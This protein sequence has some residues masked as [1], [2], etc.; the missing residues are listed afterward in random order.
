MP[1]STGQ[2]T[3]TIAVLAALVATAGILAFL[4]LR[5]GTEA[6]SPPGV[7]QPTEIKIAPEISGRL[8]RFVVVAGQG[9]Q[10]G[11]ILAELANPELEAALVLAKAQLGQERAERD[12]VYAGPRQEEIDSRQRAVEMAEA[13][14]LYARQQFFRASQLSATGFASRQDFDKA[15]A[16]V[17][18]ALANLSRANEEY[19]AARLGPTREERTIADAKV[20]SAAAAVAVIAARVAKLRIRAPSAGTVALLVAEPAEAVI[21]GQPI[22]T[23]QAAGQPWASFNLREDRL[24]ELGIG[25]PIKLVTADGSTRID[26]RIT[27]IV[28]RG[29][30][31]VWRAARAV[32]DYD[33]NTFLIRVDPA[34]GA[35]AMQP[36]MTVWLDRK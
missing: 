11:D 35:E 8:S 21:P 12:R 25:S 26:S 29:E 16:A 13:N 33:L 10:Q 5:P 34:I 1:S 9:V 20:E 15:G 17:G 27:E 28:P 22:L 7:I 2:R 31:A 30:F 32:G 24:N 4:I 18:A 36:G 23:L 14:L 6:Q 3:H 19:Q